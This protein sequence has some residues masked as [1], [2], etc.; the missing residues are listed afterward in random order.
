VIVVDTNVLAYLLLGGARTP[1]ARRALL[2]DPEWG[3]PVLWR[4]EFRSVLAGFLRGKALALPDALRV[5]DEAETLVE[6][7]GGE[8]RVESTAVLELVSISRCSAYDC[9]FVALAR[10]LGVSLVTTDREILLEFPETAV[11]LDE[12]G[13]G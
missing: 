8:Y 2:R 12:F 11:A 13:R 1:E 5:M 6:A 4:S 10:E 9:E 3:A 7:G